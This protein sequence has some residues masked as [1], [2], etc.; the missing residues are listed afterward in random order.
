[1]IVPLDRNL[2]ADSLDFLV[3]WTA[4]SALPCSTPTI[5]EICST[6]KVVVVD[7]A[8]SSTFV[9]V[10]NRRHQP[11][12]VVLMVFPKA[13]ESLVTIIPRGGNGRLR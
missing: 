6:H 3:F 12:V 8:S 4:R 11:V 7:R 1:M 10:Q 2:P 5:T 13:L 9:G